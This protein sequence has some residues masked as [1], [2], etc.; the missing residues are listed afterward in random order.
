M[1]TL[2]QF[3]KSVINRAIAEDYPHLKLPAVVYATVTG[4]KELSDTY[5]VKELEITD[6]DGGRTFKAHYTAHWHEY[7][8]KVLDRFGNT[9][10]TFPEL[11]GVR[12]KVQLE[13]GATVAIAF[14]FGG[15]E[16]TIIGEVVL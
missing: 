12:S 16:P 3:T 5:E 13:A 1:G 4:A 9:D 11:P 15:V 10:D 2:E 14:A 6:E 7:A 8:L